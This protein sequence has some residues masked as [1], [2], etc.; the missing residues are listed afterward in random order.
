M[1]LNLA[2]L[3]QQ[4]CAVMEVGFPLKLIFL[5]NDTARFRIPLKLFGR[6]LIRDAELHEPFL[7]V[8]ECEK[9]FCH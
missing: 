8:P 5:G 1:Q 2:I 6:Q 3:L 9:D 4:G 7:H